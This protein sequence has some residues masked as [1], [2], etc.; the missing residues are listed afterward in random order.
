MG[1]VILNKRFVGGKWRDCYN[2]QECNLTQA[3]LVLCLFVVCFL[4]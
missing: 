4:L 1:P 3:A 2:D